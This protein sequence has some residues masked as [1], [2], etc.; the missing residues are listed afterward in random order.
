MALIRAHLVLA[1][2]LSLFPASDS[3]AASGKGV[4]ITRQE[5][6]L[7][8]EINGQHFC[9]YNFEG[10]PRPYIYP[11]YSHNGLGMTRNWPMK[12][13][14]GEERD[15]VHHRGLY[16]GHRH[17]NGVSFW[18]E[19]GRQGTIKHVKFSQVK[20]GKDVGV[21]TAHSD[22]VSK[23]GQFV[24]SDETTIRIYNRKDDRILD[25]EI[26][27]I[28]PPDKE[29]VFGDDKDAGMAIRIAESMRLK[30]REGKKSL[31]GDGHIVMPTGVRDGDTWG[32]Q[33][34]WCDYHGPVE[35]KVMGVAIF[36][37]PSNPRHPTWWH[38]RDY[39]LFTANPFG[40]R[41]FE[42]LEDKNAGD[43]KLPAGERVTFRYRFYWH[44]GDEIQGNV[45]ERYQEYLKQVKVAAK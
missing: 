13:V 22:W 17:V 14:E 4:T 37:H 35:G 21:I 27:L 16:Y 26:T 23:E 32:K 39:G 15:H 3:Q 19:T 1:L 11:I 29:V 40:K 41:H 18:E 45:A 30:K 7:R 20:N 33:S 34:P 38:V 36:D 42:K 44:E 31:P 10:A 12:E 43:L 6:K 8:V 2:A 5:G 28:A 9:D 25:Y 24:C